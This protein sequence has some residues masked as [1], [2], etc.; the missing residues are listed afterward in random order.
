M[1]VFISKEFSGYYK[2]APLTLVDIG[3]RGG[4]QKNWDRAKRHIKIIGFEP[5]KQEFEKLEKSSDNATIKYINA[6]LYKDKRLVEFYLT[7]NRGV[8]SMFKPNMELLSGFPEAERFEIEETMK[9]GTDSL[10]DQ[11]KENNIEDIDF[12]KIDTHGS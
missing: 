1:D 5:D 10:D 8:S 4:L 6:A 2:K 9:L 11:L 3:A 12:I 7:K